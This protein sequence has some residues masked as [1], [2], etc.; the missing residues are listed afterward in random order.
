MSLTKTQLRDFVRSQLDVDEEE[1]PN[2]RLDLYLADAFWSTVEAEQRW[3]MY[4]VEAQ[5]TFTDGVAA[6]P[7]SLRGIETLYYNDQLPFID[8]GTVERAFGAPAP[9]G[10]PRFFTIRN[11]QIL[12]YPA[13]EGGV[14]AFAQGWRTP[15]DFLLATAGDAPDCDERLHYALIYFACSI[16]QAANEDEVL[17][18]LYY[19]QWE[20]AVERARRD[21]MRPHPARSRILNGG[22]GKAVNRTSYWWA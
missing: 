7:A 19:S 18:G 1:L 10:I 4:E 8:Y 12:M 15:D 13:Q 6:M 21:I 3:P 22:V 17:R 2:D 5:I 9:F 11:Q 20:A 14:E 16:A